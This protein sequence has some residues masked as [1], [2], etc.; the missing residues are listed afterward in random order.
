MEISHDTEG[1][2]VK[3]AIRKPLDGHE[4]LRRDSMLKMVGPMVAKRFRAAIVM[5]N[6]VPPIT[7]ESQV[8]GYLKEIWQATGPDFLPLM[9]LYL[10]DTLEP[11]H[12][13]ALVGVG[14]V[15]G[16]KYYPRGLTTNSDSGVKNPSS[17]W[18]SG[19]RPY[20]CL[21]AL[22]EHG[23][24]LLLHA[25]DG[26]DENGVELDPFDQEK[27]FIEHTLPRIRDAHPK[28]KISVEHLST[29][30]GVEYLL[31]HG[32]P[33]LGCSL[34]AQHLLL[35][36]R[37]WL[38]GGFHPQRFW[39]PIIQP[40][41]HREALRVL[42]K[43]D[44]PFVWLGSD[45]AP[46]PV[47]KKRA[48]CCAGGVLMAHAGIELYVEAF[49]NM[50]ALDDRFERFASINGARF[51]GLGD[52]D[53]TIELVREEWTVRHSPHIADGGTS[54]EVIPFRLGEKIRWKL[55]A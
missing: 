2:P 45:S 4:H 19:T 13:E 42:A 5:P 39:W 30:W 35:D 16:I 38:R 28:L 54:K 55:V 6:T 40:T 23:G 52:S 11:S 18:T 14:T 32:G 15:K 20:E 36:R 24:V 47:E 9:T 27:H 1:L 10:T 46:H 12:V 29:K 21:Q 3:I 50:G 44:K 41:E 33:L 34:T 26:F 53:E 37:D 8:C 7:T 51:Y 49:E 17:L 22:A 43:A 48:D 31:K 25:A